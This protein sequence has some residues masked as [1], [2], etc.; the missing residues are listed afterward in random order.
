MYPYPILELGNIK[1]YLYGVCIAVGILLCVL[2]LFY[3]TKKKNMA[4][5]LQDFIFFV[6]VFTVAGGFLF[7]KLFQATYDWIAKGYFDFASAGITA[8]GGFFGGALIFIVLYF[9]IGNLFFK[10]RNPGI[11]KKQFHIMLRV[12]PCCITIAHALGRIGCLFAGCCHGALLSSSQSAYVF[13][14]IWMKGTYG[15]G[16]Y[17]PTQLYEALFLLALF[18]ALTILYSR[19]FALTH[20]VYLIGYGAWRIF[21]EFF[22]TDYRGAIVLGLSPSQWFS[23]VFILGGVAFFVYYYIR[24][25]KLFL[26]EPRLFS[27]PVKEEGNDNIEN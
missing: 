12:A 8:M 6:A 17:V 7:A 10:K 20:A 5:E 13:G 21:I 16:Y 1:V 19:G 3:Y 11:H 25:K 4:Q 2:V 15:W 22:R 9:P 18:V 24:K 26:D 23:I 27:K 14:G